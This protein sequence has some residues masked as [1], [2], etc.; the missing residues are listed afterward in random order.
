MTITLVG[1][2]T[3][4]TTYSVALNWVAGSSA[5][6]GYNLYRGTVSGGPYT[7]M[8]S[9]ALSGTTY[10]DSSV[11]AGQTYYYVAT[12]LNSSGQESSYSNQV[13]EAIP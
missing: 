6:V 7:K 12:D 5:A 2:G 8:N 3:S 13:T 1:T 11:T 10:T 9:S 4:P